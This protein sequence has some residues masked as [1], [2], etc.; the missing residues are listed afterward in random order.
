MNA[1]DGIR[2]ATRTIDVENI[3]SNVTPEILEITI[4]KLRIVISGDTGD[5]N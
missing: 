1:S 5:H 3:H 2:T 4:D